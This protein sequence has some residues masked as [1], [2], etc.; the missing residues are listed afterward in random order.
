[1]HFYLNSEFN[2]VLVY[3]VRS[4]CMYESVLYYKHFISYKILLVSL[5]LF[6]TEIKYSYYI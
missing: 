5:F 2:C 4:L 6:L 3:Y 1:M